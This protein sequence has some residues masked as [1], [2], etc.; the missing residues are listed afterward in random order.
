MHIYHNQ[1]QAAQ[2]KVTDVLLNVLQHLSVPESSGIEKASLPAKSNPSNWE[3][4]LFIWTLLI[5]GQA[6]FNVLINLKLH[7]VIHTGKLRLRPRL[8]CLDGTRR[9][10]CVQFPMTV[11]VLVTAGNSF[12]TDIN[13][14][15]HVPLVPCLY[16]LPAGTCASTYECEASVQVPLHWLCLIKTDKKDPTARANT[17]AFSISELTC[18]PSLR[19]RADSKS[20]DFTRNVF[21]VVDNR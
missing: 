5:S 11:K 19:L 17:F 2:N 21:K 6:L 14:T 16:V 1:L 15:L 9:A 13:H 8:T 18:G 20:G 3:Q 12:S 4:S 10:I 7:K